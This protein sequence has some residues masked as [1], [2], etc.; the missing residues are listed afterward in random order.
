ME[1]VEGAGLVVIARLELDSKAGLERS[2]HAQHL[3]L[4]ARREVGVL[5]IVQKLVQW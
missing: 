5:L 2:Y 4:L 3:G 1:K